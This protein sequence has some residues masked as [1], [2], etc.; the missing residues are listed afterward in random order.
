MLDERRL[1]AHTL[2]PVFM[3]RE[4]RKVVEGRSVPCDVLSL[5]IVPDDRHYKRKR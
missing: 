2:H 3:A 1:G 4:V 5:L